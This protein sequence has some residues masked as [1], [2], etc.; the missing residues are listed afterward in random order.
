[1]PGLPSP[2]RPVLCTYIVDTFHVKTRWWGGTTGG[3]PSTYLVLV[4]VDRETPELKS[5]R[6]EHNNECEQNADRRNTHSE[7][8]FLWGHNGRTYQ[9]GSASLTAALIVTTPAVFEYTTI[10]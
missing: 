2:H 10:G 5:E 1:M 8:S 7:P 3:R 6:G 9:R 4:N